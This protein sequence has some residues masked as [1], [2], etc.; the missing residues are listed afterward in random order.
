MKNAKQIGIAIGVGLVALAAAYGVGR[1]QTAGRVDDAE[2]RA[3]AAASAS[4]TAVDVARAN[5]DVCR[6]NVTRLEA[7]RQLD[8]ALIALEERNFG[9]AQERLESSRAFLAATKGGD[10]ELA[11]LAGEIEATKLV[12]AEDLGDQRKKLL[13]LLKRLDELVPA[14]KNP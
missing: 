10:P 9:I 1:L 14:P 6:G 5:L 13:G 4:A 12:A 8:L 2:R 7:R 11:K 3:S